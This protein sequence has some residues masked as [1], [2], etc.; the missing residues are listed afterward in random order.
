MY[1]HHKRRHVSV[2]GYAFYFI[3]V[4]RHGTDGII[5][6]VYNK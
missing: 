4:I 2:A 6:K 1:E 3:T 5:K